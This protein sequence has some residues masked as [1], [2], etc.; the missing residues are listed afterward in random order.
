MEE[1]NG[2]ELTYKS[3]DIINKMTSLTFLLRSIEMVITEESLEPTERAPYEGKTFT[4]ALYEELEIMENSINKMN[5]KILKNF[6][7]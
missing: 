6:G 7:K 1:D 4:E 3:F 2:E 5:D